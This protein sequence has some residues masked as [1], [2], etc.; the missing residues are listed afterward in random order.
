M[1]CLVYVQWNMAWPIVA[2]VHYTAEQGTGNRDPDAAVGV[3]KQVR[4][5]NE[6]GDGEML[7][8]TKN[9]NFDYASVYITRVCDSMAQKV[10][11]KECAFAKKYNHSL[12][13]KPK[14]GECITGP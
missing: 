12:V 14:N 6:P 4:S 10:G 9:C 13:L 11:N 1:T 3:E 7:L 8:T 2:K 5:G